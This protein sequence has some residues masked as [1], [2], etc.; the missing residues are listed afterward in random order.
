MKAKRIAL[1]GAPPAREPAP[2]AA[3]PEP[4]TGMAGPTTG[5]AGSRGDPEAVTRK[6]LA[7][8]AC[9]EN[10]EATNGAPVRTTDVGRWE[11]AVPA[12]RLLVVLLLG[13]FVGTREGRGAGAGCTTWGAERM[14][15]VPRAAS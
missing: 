9:D 11:D 7:G 6:C 4:P 12:E 10:V 8:E 3:A 5:A 1:I 13:L 2:A 15:R 14:P